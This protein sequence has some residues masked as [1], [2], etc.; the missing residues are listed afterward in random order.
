MR[1]S[2]KIGAF[3]ILK[4]VQIFLAILKNVCTFTIE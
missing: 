4:K 3:F 2:V 1:S